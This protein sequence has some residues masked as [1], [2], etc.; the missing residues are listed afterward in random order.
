MASSVPMHLLHN[1]STARPQKSLRRLKCTISRSVRGMQVHH[2]GFALTARRT[3]ESSKVAA[4]DR[5]KCIT[6]RNRK[7]LRV[8]VTRVL[9]MYETPC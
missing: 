9:I 8:N 1:V 2:I 5:H 7:S 3:S 6:N 4:V